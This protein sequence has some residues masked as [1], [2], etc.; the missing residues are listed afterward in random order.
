[1]YPRALKCALNSFKMNNCSFGVKI[2]HFGQ[3]IGHFGQKIDY[4]T[5]ILYNKIV[6]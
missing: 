1:M 2:G 3:K 4:V 5:I 6:Q